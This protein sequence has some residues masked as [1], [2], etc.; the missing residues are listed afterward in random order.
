LGRVASHHSTFTAVSSSAP[1][2]HI[3][4]TLLTGNVNLFSSV[5][6]L[7]QK[8]VIGKLL[9]WLS[10]DQRSSPPKFEHLHIIKY[11]FEHFKIEAN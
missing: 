2:S 10:K 11:M 6:P 8:F 7:L 1:L 4:H 3:Q 5:V 9:H